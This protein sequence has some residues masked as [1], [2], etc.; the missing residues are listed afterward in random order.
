MYDSKNALVSSGLIIDSGNDTI[1]IWAKDQDF[2]NMPL[3]IPNIQNFDGRA[4]RKE[5]SILVS[6]SENG[7]MGTLKVT[8]E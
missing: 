5:S 6:N 3:W 2:I 1:E 4:G 8:G 7:I